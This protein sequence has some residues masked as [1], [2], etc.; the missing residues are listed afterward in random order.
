[1]DH[2]K[3]YDDH[4]YKVHVHSLY[5]EEGDHEHHIDHHN[6]DEVDRNRPSVVHDEV[7]TYIENRSSLDV[8][9]CD[10]DNRVGVGYNLEDDGRSRRVEVDTLDEEAIEI[11]NVHAFG[12]PW[13]IV[14]Y[15]I[16]SF[17][18]NNYC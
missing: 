1:M 12:H 6:C 8:E 3:V 5:E 9:E 2:H 4:S 11:D 17:V 14:G 15:G 10:Y 16:V 18:G 7:E 13:A